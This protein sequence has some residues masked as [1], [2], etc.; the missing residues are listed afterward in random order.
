MQQITKMQEQGVEIRKEMAEEQKKA[1]IQHQKEMQ[2]RT[3][4]ITVTKF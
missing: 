3:Q 4:E 2:L 1:A